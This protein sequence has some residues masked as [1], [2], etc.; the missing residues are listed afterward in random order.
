MAPQ[1]PMSLDMPLRTVGNAGLLSPQ[2]P[3]GGSAFRALNPLATKVTTVL[4]TSYS[5]TEFRD[6]LLLVD[7]RGIQNDP[8]TRRHIRLD[9]QKEVIDS[10]GEI[11]TEFGY[12]AE[13]CPAGDCNSGH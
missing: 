2:T 10:N 8:K 12:V 4:S 3:S 7:G 13:V 11:I 6:A 9:L 5:D 1:S